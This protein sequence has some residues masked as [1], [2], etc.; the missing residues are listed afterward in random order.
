MKKIKGIKKF[1]F[2]EPKF[3]VRVGS[4]IS[5][6]LLIWSILN[7][8]EYRSKFLF[9]F[10]V[11]FLVAGVLKEYR[12]G[13]FKVIMN[14]V[15]KKTN[16]GVRTKNQRIKSMKKI[17]NNQTVG[18]I[19]NVKKPSTPVSIPPTLNRKSGPEAPKLISKKPPKL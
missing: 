11:S 6:W 8:G 2:K 3:T 18:K 15:A 4:I 1:N 16:K 13:T 5:I 9:A 7:F 10:S 19:A 14:F 17:N 12:N